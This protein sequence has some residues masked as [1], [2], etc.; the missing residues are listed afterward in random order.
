M[1][2][3]DVER[4]GLMPNVE[5]VRVP[6]STSRN[7]APQ[8]GLFTLLRGKMQRGIQ[9]APQSIE[10]YVEQQFAHDPHA[11][12]LWK[13]TVPWTEAPGLLE[14]CNQH[15]INGAILFPGYDGAAKAAMDSL[16][17]S[18]RVRALLAE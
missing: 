6:G 8:E 12:P 7:L 13:L 17:R 15:G 4:R 11:L 16:L 1:W 18:D 14:R 2:A 3:F 10:K 9:Y 5:I